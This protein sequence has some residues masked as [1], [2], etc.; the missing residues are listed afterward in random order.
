MAHAHARLATR[1]GRRRKLRAAAVDG[2]QKRQ[3]PRELNARASEEG[4]QFRRR[5]LVALCT[6]SFHAA[7]ALAAGTGHSPVDARPVLAQ[8]LEALGHHGT[9]VHVI[10]AQEGVCVAF[11]LHGAG[12]GRQPKRTPAHHPREP[13]R[14]WAGI[15]TDEHARTGCPVAAAQKHPARLGH[16]A[17]R[18]A[19]RSLRAGC[20]LLSA[21][22]RLLS[23][24]RV[25]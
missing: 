1:L 2:Q 8:T 20:S 18:L 15:I 6:A 13:L 23:A 3:L 19:Q 14:D 11:D 17:A 5:G 21:L 24:A 25:I 10:R 7:L 16:H 4:A 22:R 12:H 9:K